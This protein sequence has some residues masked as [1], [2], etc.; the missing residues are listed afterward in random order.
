MT[1]GPSCPILALHLI[2]FYFGAEA[3]LTPTSPPPHPSMCKV[4]HKIHTDLIDWHMPNLDVVRQDSK[5]RMPVLHAT[6][7]LEIF[8]S[9]KPPCYNKYPS[10]TGSSFNISISVADLQYDAHGHLS[11]KKKKKK[12]KKKMSIYIPLRKPF[13]NSAHQEKLIT[14]LFLSRSI[15]LLAEFNFF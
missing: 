13:F 12:K 7:L 15:W 9:K 10:T 5:K 1:L 4:Y 6:F 3:A 14:P 11:Q 2:N 8:S